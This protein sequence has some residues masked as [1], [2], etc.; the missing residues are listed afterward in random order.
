MVEPIIDFAALLAETIAEQRS[1]CAEIWSE[2]LVETLSHVC[3]TCHQSI[4]I[5]IKSYSGE[6]SV[7]TVALSRTGYTIIFD[8][9]YHVKF[10]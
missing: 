8:G 1:G 4:P 10:D 9:I 2:P 6:A 5:V 7:V 3:V